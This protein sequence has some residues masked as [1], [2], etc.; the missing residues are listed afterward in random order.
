MDNTYFILK[1]SDKELT[2]VTLDTDKEGI[3]E[4]GRDE[5]YDLTGTRGYGVETFN[6]GEVCGYRVNLVVSFD[7]FAIVVDN[8]RYVPVEGKNTSKVGDVDEYRTLKLPNNKEIDVTGGIMFCTFKDFI[9][10]DGESCTSY[11]GFTEGV[12]GRVEKYLSEKIIK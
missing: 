1:V 12:L 10:E 8:T 7:D 5:L 2:K 11:S 6:L 3:T 4:T 9:D